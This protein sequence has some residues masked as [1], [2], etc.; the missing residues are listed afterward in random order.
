[1]A[2]FTVKSSPQLVE[3]YQLL[4]Q[5]EWTEQ[6]LA[7]TINL[8]RDEVK[9]SP[10]PAAQNFLQALY[11][12]ATPERSHL[13]A[14]VRDR[15]RTFAEMFRNQV[16]QPLREIPEDQLNSSHAHVTEVT[17]TYL[18]LQS[19]GDL[20]GETGFF[21]D[22][23]SIL[24]NGAAQLLLPILQKR[25]AE[26]LRLYLADALYMHTWLVWEKNPQ[27]KFFLQSVLMEE[28]GDDAA[29]LILLRR[30]FELTPV[31]DHSYL[32]K[33]QAVWSDLVDRRNFREAEQFLLNLY[34]YS[35]QSY[36]SEIMKMIHSTYRMAFQSALSPG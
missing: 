18:I 17:W 30:A 27:H 26:G 24:F 34:R 19:I 7:D 35:P 20:R 16:A 14:S 5:S 36:L 32:T 1:M 3:R 21:A 4:L 13:A 8:L 29:R 15:I 9:E 31:D 28:L 12:S 23:Q 11:S 10:D 33:A 22:T 25:K 2:E 6:T